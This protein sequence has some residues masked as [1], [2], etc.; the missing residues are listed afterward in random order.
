M[1][2][3]I[4][5][6]DNVVYEGESI[7]VPRVGDTIERDGEALPIEA[8]SWDLGDRGPTVRLLLAARPYAY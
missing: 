4:L 3:R 7:P 1:S 6:D 5:I 8:V 2:I